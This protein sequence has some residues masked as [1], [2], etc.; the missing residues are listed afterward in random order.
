[1]FSQMANGGM[2]E[3]EQHLITRTM[4]VFEHSSVTC[5]LSLAHSSGYLWRSLGFEE[6]VERGGGGRANNIEHCQ[7]MP[8]H[9]QLIGLVFS[10]DS[11]CCTRFYIYISVT[12]LHSTCNRFHAFLIHNMKLSCFVLCL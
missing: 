3:A 9:I 10:S 2:V 1:M 6:M 12:Y 8:L 5:G 4:F 11:F 7:H